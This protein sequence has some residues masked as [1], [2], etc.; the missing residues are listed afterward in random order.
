MRRP[1]TEWHREVLDNGILE[2]LDSATEGNSE[3]LSDLAER[4]PSP[5]PGETPEQI[6]KQIGFWMVEEDD[7][8]DFSTPVMDDVDGEEGKKMAM[9]YI[10]VKALEFADIGS[11]PDS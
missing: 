3:K 5:Q 7:T 4:F 10:G 6:A 1:R 8:G 2:N 9:G 11:E